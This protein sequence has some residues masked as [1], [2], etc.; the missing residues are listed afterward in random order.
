VLTGDGELRARHL[1][2]LQQII[3]RMSQN[4]FTIRGWSITLVTAAFALLA[5]QDLDRRVVLFALIPTWI[6]WGLD[7]SYFRTERLFRALYAAAVRRLTDP[8]AQPDVRPFDTDTSPFKKTTATWVRLL[9]SPSVA[10]IP[11]LLT[12]ATI[13]YAAVA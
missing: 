7:A 9:L 5:T 10:A 2:M 11:G 12:M 3:A 1:E 6:F 13:A 8:D 4:S